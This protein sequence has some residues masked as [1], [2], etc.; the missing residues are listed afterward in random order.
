[1]A[2]EKNKIESSG[3]SIKK[4]L[5]SKKAEVEKLI[6]QS[7]DELS[8][9]ILQPSAIP[10]IRLPPAQS[11]YS[12]GTSSN[13]PAKQCLPYRSRRKS[14]KKAQP[15]IPHGRNLDV[16]HYTPHIPLIR[17]PCEP[18][19]P[20]ALRGYRPKGRFPFL[21]LPGELRNKIYAYVIKKKHYAIEWVCDNN[22]SKSLTHWIREARGMPGPYLKLTPENAVRRRALDTAKGRT[23]QRLP[24]EYFGRTDVAILLVCKQMH[25]EASSVLY[26]ECTFAFHGIRALDHFLDC[27]QPA[28]KASISQIFI[29]YRAYGYPEYVSNQCWKDR[30]D[31][32]WETLCWRVADECTSLTKLSL[33]LR[34]NKSPVSFCGF[35]EIE[36]A[37]IGAQWIRP[38]RAFQYIGIKR[39]SARVHCS[40]KERSVLE[41]GSWSIRKEILG[42]SWDQE[43]ESERD[44]FGRGKLRKEPKEI[45]E[46]RVL[47]ITAAGNVEED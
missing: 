24:D 9:S 25:E 38:L 7:K 19:V 21:K 18:D 2:N 37:G 11:S 27:L 32:R 5:S 40:V 23:P 12:V 15:N 31:R 30:H 33:D 41:W 17:L 22:K 36:A 29:K 3:F 35:D 43:I 44:S 10:Y 47:R 28:A 1:M 39:C 46:G 20:R 26:S 34:L 6:V 16:G 4:G 8:A 45:K 13:N 42:D 14:P